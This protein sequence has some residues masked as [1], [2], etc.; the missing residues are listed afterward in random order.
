MTANWVLALLVTLLSSL[1]LSSEAIV[2]DLEQ[3]ETRRNEICYCA[4]NSYDFTLDFTLMCPPVNI[5][6][7]DAISATTCTVSPFEK[8]TVIDLVPVSVDWIEILEM[9]Q[10]FVPISWQYKAGNFSDGDTFSYTSQASMAGIMINQE[11]IVKAIQLNIYGINKDGEKIINFYL[12][13]F[14]NFCEAYPVLSDGQFAGWT[15]FVRF[16]NGSFEFDVP[17]WE[18]YSRRTCSKLCIML[19]TLL[20][21]LIHK[22]LTFIYSLFLKSFFIHVLLVE[23]DTA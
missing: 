22:P 20:S 4:P 14:T 9:N 17:S 5:T 6:L 23:F 8:S 7:G 11:N 21:L 19:N 15:R 1:L 16:W 18:C 3:Q 2:R 10:H 13:T 12:I